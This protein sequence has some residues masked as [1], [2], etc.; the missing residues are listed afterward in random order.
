M[1]W[2]LAGC[3]Q[4]PLVAEGE[5]WPL[6]LRTVLPAEV[7]LLRAFDRVLGPLDGAL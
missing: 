7:L 4:R 6:V 2:P 1:R 5:Q 3:A